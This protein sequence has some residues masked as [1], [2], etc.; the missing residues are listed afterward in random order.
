[1]YKIRSRFLNKYASKHAYF[2][3]SNDAGYDDTMY[4]FKDSNSK[5]LKCLIFYLSSLFKIFLQFFT[6][7]T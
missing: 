4:L 5:S 1:M 3:F 7:L 6:T 2:I